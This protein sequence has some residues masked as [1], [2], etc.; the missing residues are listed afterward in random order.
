MYRSP[1][2]IILCMPPANERRRYIVTSPLI[3]WAHTQNNPCSWYVKYLIT[4]QRAWPF[5]CPFWL[6]LWWHGI[7]PGVSTA[8]TTNCSGKLPY[9]PS[10]GWSQ[11]LPVIIIDFTYNFI[12]DQHQDMTYCFMTGPLTTDLSHILYAFVFDPN[13]DLNSYL[14]TGGQVMIIYFSKLGH[15]RLM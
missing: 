7:T 5:E 3:G 8:E 9:N 10:Q 4:W 15:H 11:Y 1:A 13:L 12:N 6:L 14:T 2:G